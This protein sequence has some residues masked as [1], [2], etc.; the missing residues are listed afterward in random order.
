[1]SNFNGLSFIFDGI[2][3]ENFGLNIYNFDSDGGLKEG[4]G[5]SVEINQDWLFRRTSPYLYG[6]MQNK[7]MEFD[8]TFGSTNAVCADDKAIIF[9][10]LFG[11]QQYKK[12]QIVQDDLSEVYFNVVFTEMRNDYIGNTAYAFT[13]HA[14]CDAP[15]SW[16]FDKVYEQTFVNAQ[17]NFEFDIYND[18]SNNDYTYPTIEVILSS[19]N[20]GGYWELLDYDANGDLVCNLRFDGLLPSEKLII[21]NSR[22]IIDSYILSGGNYIPSGLRRLSKVT[23]GK[24]TFFRMVKGRNQIVSSGFILGLK[25]NYQFAKRVGI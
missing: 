8:I 23:E 4:N 12:L 13:A 20:S 11:H 1:M 17:A 7:P 6:V 16:S 22:R 14:V 18:T 15:W 10:W 24:D 19:T 25:L 3:S 9:G 21:D 2:P 5:N